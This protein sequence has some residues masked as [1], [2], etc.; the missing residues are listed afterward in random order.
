[1][2][3]WGALSA[4][5]RSERSVTHPPH[6]AQQRRRDVIELGRLAEFSLALGGRH[7]A[8]EQLLRHVEDAAR[9]DLGAAS[10]AG[11]TPQTPTSS[12]AEELGW[13]LHQRGSRALL[14]DELGEA[15]S[16]CNESLRHREDEDGRELTRKNMGLIPLAVVP[17]AALLLIPLFLTLLVAPH[18]FPFRE[19][20]ATVDVTPD[21]WD[22][23]QAGRKSFTVRNVGDGKVWIERIGVIGEATDFAV[24]ELADRD[25]RCTVGGEIAQG[26]QCTVT[27]ESKGR[28]ATALLEIDVVSRS[29]ES[30]GDQRIVLVSTPS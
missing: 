1:M 23:D 27:V 24:V 4:D 15:R 12:T 26:G 2:M 8:W 6:R 5:G 13:A 18:V 14:R 28:T 22:A 20:M 17:F 11:A 25:A 10:D 16:L 30:S 7:G 29:G 3:E 9:A 21:L 19:A